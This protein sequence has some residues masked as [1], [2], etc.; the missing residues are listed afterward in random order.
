LAINAWASG[1]SND[2][3]FAEGDWNGDHEF[4]SADLVLAFQTSKY[5][6][7]ALLGAAHVPV[8]ESLFGDENGWQRGK[9]SLMAITR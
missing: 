9:G 5:V 2:T 8:I 1:F 4:D 6:A 3:K 7:E